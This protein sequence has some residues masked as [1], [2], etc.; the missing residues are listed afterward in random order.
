M[1]YCITAL[2]KENFG[3]MCNFYKKYL[4]KDIVCIQVETHG[5]ILNL[6]I[7]ASYMM[8]RPLII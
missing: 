7:I 3:K 1:L 2:I 8:V 5:N 4:V 6:E